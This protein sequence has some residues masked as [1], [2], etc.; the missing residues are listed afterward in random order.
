MCCQYVINFS[1][2]GNVITTVKWR[3][4]AFSV[5]ACSIGIGFSVVPYVTDILL[6]HYGWRGTMLLLGGTTLNCCPAFLAIDVFSRELAPK[7]NTNKTLKMKSHWN[8]SLFKD[9]GFLAVGFNIFMIMALIP[10]VNLFLVDI[11]KSKGLDEST[12]RFFVILS[13]ISSLVGRIFCVALTMIS[14]SSTILP[15]GVM[16]I[17]TGTSI[18]MLALA[19]NYASMAAVIPLYNITFGIQA[20]LFPS[21]IYEVV[22]VQRYTSAVGYVGL[23]GGIAIW[24]SGPIGGKIYCVCV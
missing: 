2:V 5:V 13:G 21:A 24:I 8:L 11:S 10:S 17:A 19:N 15:I 20:V 14:I 9:F 12:G 23:I 3:Q 16:Y 4:F 7:K 1:V 22:G 6:Q 18:A